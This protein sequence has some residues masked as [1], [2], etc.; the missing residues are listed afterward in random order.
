VCVVPVNIHLKGEGLR[1]ILAHARAAGWI[2]ERRLAAELDPLAAEIGPAHMIWRG[3]P[4]H[5]AALEEIC[6]CG[7][8]A[9]PPFDRKPF[10][11]AALLYTSG[12]TGLPKAVMMTDSMLRCAAHGAARLSAA[13]D[14][15][16]FYFWEPL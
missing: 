10:D 9:P 8:P 6:E 5:G 4:G 12:T 14:G 2:A 3:R 13:R 15:D 16:V 1:F 7:D 11:V